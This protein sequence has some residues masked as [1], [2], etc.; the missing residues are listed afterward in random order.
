MRFRKIALNLVLLRGC[1]VRDLTQLKSLI[2]FSPRQRLCSHQTF[3]PSWVV[4]QVHQVFDRGPNAVNDALVLLHNFTSC[5]A[6][7]ISLGLLTSLHGCQG[8]SERSG[9]QEPYL[10]L[11]DADMTEAAGISRM[12]MALYS[13][14]Y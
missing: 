3:I 4:R 9:N 11:L 2:A 8:P 10:M 14:P 1:G 13:F 6:C 5:P 12:P 7:Y